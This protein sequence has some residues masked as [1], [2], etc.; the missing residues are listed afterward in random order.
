[1]AFRSAFVSAALPTL[2][3]RMV[4][5]KEVLKNQEARREEV[6][7]DRQS[8]RSNRAYAAFVT[9]CLYEEDVNHCALFAYTIIMRAV[10]TRRRP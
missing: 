10:R 4:K 1:M 9:T 6:H 2:T 8:I 3:P 5:G 7:K